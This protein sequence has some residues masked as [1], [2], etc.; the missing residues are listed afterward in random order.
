MAPMALKLRTGSEQYAPLACTIIGGLMASA[1][2]TRYIVPAAV[3]E[4][5][6]LQFKHEGN[7]KGFRRYWTNHV[8]VAEGPFNPSGKSR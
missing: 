5:V 8:P 3:A 4:N 1:I 7:Q 2:L 6:Q